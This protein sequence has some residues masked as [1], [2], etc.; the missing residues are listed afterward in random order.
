MIFFPSV[1]SIGMRAWIALG[2]LISLAA[3][4]ALVWYYTRPIETRLLYKSFAHEYKERA[5]EYAYDYAVVHGVPE[6]MAA[7][8]FGNPRPIF[9]NDDYYT[10]AN[11]YVFPEDYSFEPVYK[12]LHTQAKQ[13]F[14]DILTSC[15]ARLENFFDDEIVEGIPVDIIYVSQQLRIA[16]VVQRYPTQNVSTHGW[17]S[18]TANMALVTVPYGFDYFGAPY[19][20]S[21]SV[22]SDEELAKRLHSFIYSQLT[23]MAN[24]AGCT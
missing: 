18:P 20:E 5:R 16:L 8:V 3:V 11:D 12:K 13:S 21:A 10:E 19:R 9:H 14:V 22:E 7:R 24:S 4:C 23:S 15:G 6:N 2:A 1:P 17:S